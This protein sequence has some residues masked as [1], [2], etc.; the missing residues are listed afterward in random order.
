[1]RLQ[2]QLTA[3]AK[4]QHTRVARFAVKRQMAAGII[5]L[6]EALRRPECQTMRLP[7]L[8][9]AQPWWGDV[10][11]RKALKTLR[12]AGVDSELRVGELTGKQRLLVVL[13]CLSHEPVR[14]QLEAAGA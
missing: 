12:S 11:A 4:A 13:V 8:L 10:R 14:V 3:L 7:S 5:S 6:R 1:V 2:Q 9:V